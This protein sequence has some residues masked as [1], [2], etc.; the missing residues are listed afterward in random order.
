MKYE[1]DYLWL[2]AIAAVAAAATITIPV[3]QYLT[4]EQEQDLG[5]AAENTRRRI[6]ALAD[7][8]RE[9]DRVENQMAGLADPSDIEATIRQRERE[10]RSSSLSRAELLDTSR[11]LAELR[12]GLTRA[13][14]RVLDEE[15]A[16]RE[17]QET[18]KALTDATSRGEGE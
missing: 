11:E 8:I 13:R 2:A 7:E 16:E 12:D 15:R 9:R 5:E 14:E 18:V 10:L 3:A 6:Q 17:F 1:K 4:E